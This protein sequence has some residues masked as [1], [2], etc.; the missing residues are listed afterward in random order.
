MYC[1]ALISALG[2]Y[3]YTRSCAGGWCNTLIDAATCDIS[4]VDVL[5]LLLLLTCCGV[6]SLWRVT[7][8]AAAC[9]LVA[10]PSKRKPGDPLIISD[11]KKAS[12]A[13]R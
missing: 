11:V 1:A 7:L 12:V 4:S 2:W 10:A 9:W 8:T 3:N 13:H 5:L 6:D